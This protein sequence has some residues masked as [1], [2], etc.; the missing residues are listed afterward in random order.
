MGD[1]FVDCPWWPDLFV[2]TG[3]TL[4]SGT[5]GRLPFGE[6]FRRG[7]ATPDA[8]A[9]TT[10]PF[11]YGPGRFPFFGGDGWH[12]E[13]APALRRHP[14]LERSRHRSLAGLFAHHRIRAIEIA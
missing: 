2:E 7:P 8:A 14:N 13:L 6:R 11:L 10:P 4:L 12:D 3:E 5:L 1:A 9:G